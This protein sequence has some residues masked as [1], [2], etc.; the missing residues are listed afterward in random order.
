[1]HAE[2]I[3]TARSLAP[4]R[5][6]HA[7]LACW[8][9]VVPLWAPLWLVAPIVAQDPVLVAAGADA[10]TLAAAA[11]R[12]R[13]SPRQLAWQAHGF[14]AFVHFGMNT[15]TDREWGD[16]TETPATFAPTD[17]DAAQWVSTF[18]DAGM[19]GL[20][21]TCKHHDGFAL[22][23]TSVTAH[24]VASSPWRHGD[25]DIVAEVAD[26]C[27]AR[28]L[29]FGV[30]LSPWDRHCKEFGT[31]AYHEIFQTQLRELCTNY[32]PLF[33]VWFDGANCP[34]DQPEV[35]DWQAHFRLVRQLQPDAA[36]AITGPDVRW[37]GNEAG[38][39]R[40]Q[41]WSVLPLDV[42]ESGGFEQD[43]TAWQSLWRLRERNQAHDLGSR[44]ALTG[45]RRLCWWP[46][47]TDVSI[48]PGWFFHEAENDRVKSKGELLDFWFAAVGG[49]AVLLLN[50][51]PDRRGRIADQ[52]VA[53]LREVGAHLQAT[54]G[55]DLLAQA[56]RRDRRGTWEFYFAEERT[57]DVVDLRE[58]V[59]SR[60]Q[61]VEAFAI[62]VW[63][64]ERFTEVATGTTIGFRRLVRLPLTTARGLRVRIRQSRSETRLAHISLHRQPPPAPASTEPTKPSSRPR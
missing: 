38:R 8:L 1:M 58:E 60:G 48:R 26:A 46:A 16:G 20:V 34:S 53:V 49:N 14:V 22:W 27:R 25:G 5:K 11:A 9:L 50:V 61:C 63:D 24:S 12:V 42:A 21:L 56:D 29:S 59:G 64:G 13:P 36:I 44:S 28:G 45:A 37:V 31:R 15:F 62:E 41:E 23:P 32:G 35:F 10:A 39:T 2:A 47:E 40:E 57:F 7:S 30:Y 51:P 54:F 18:A 55:I 43:R 33:E 52:D 4:A 17:F 3:A 6:T 19:R